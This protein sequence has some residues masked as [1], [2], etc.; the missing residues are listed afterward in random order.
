VAHHGSAVFSLFAKTGFQPMLMAILYTAGESP[1]EAQPPKM[2]GDRQGRAR[3]RARQVMAGRAGR[4]VEA[5]LAL[6][7]RTW[8]YKTHALQAALT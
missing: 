1:T 7:A 8:L 4:R 5:L 6:W 3:Q 2:P